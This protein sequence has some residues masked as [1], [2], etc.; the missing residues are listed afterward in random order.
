MTG[1]RRDCAV[2]APDGDLPG[3]NPA[4]VRR[5]ADPTVT[6]YTQNRPLAS[7][8]VVRHGRACRAKQAARFYRVLRWAQDRP[9]G[10]VLLAVDDLHW[11]DADSLALVA[12]CVADGL[13]AAGT[14]R[15]LAALAD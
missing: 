6:A 1:V 13:G 14:D 3:K 15:C 8:P 5:A 7:V 2:P 9:G 10:A 11:A 12:F 4:P